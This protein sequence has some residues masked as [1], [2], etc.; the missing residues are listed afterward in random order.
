MSEIIDVIYIEDEET[1]ALLFK[2]G[3]SSR[4][5]N[6]LH[7]PDSNP[8]SLKILDTP[9]YQEAR[10]IF[11]DLWVGVVNGVDLAK[12]LRSRGDGRPF[13]LMTAGDNPNPELLREL[14]L[15]YM[16]KPPDFTKLAALILSLP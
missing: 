4:G 3:L 10:A 13:F 12:L 9:Q 2:L 15:A 16:R 8:E 11:I 14:N 5:I 6:V 1:D 7:I